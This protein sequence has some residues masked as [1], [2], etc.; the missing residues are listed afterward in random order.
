MDIRGGSE[1][2]RR[3]MKNPM[4]IRRALPAAL[5]LLVATAPLAQERASAAPAN[6]SADGAGAAEP[7]GGADEGGGQSLGSKATDPTA[8][9]KSFTFT[10]VWT[11]DYYDRDRMGYALRFRPAIPFK[12][13]GIGNIMR[14]S[15]Q[16]D[17][18]GLPGYGLEDVQIF[19]LLIFPAF[20]G[21]FAIGPLLNLASAHSPTP[22]PFSIGPAIGYVRSSPTLNIGLFNQNFWGEHVGNSSFQPVLTWHFLKAFDLGAGD[23]QFTYDWEKEEWISVPLGV[24]L[25]YLAMVA[26][27][28]IRFFA[29]PQYNFRDLDGATRF[30]VQFGLVFLLP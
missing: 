16:F 5:A 8:G 4:G 3:T 14:I 21:R 13:W 25:G 7:E 12:L 17:H 28:P 11:T 10:E 27:Q 23:L 20:G 6:G 1:T 9:L 22:S 2:E 24:Q 15:T 29:A 19:D 18:G 30:Q 26:K